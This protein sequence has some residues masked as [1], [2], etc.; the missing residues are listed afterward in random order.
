MKFKEI[1]SPD[2]VFPG[3]YV[4]H[5]PSSSLGLVGA[6]LGDEIRVLI[7]GKILQDKTENFRK[8]ILSK[9]EK[10][11]HQASKCKKCG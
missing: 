2:K 8:I 9:E 10:Q 3:E 1:L 6:F 11:R 5:I 4:Y 7:N